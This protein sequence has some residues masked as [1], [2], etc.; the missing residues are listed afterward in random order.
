MTI[1]VRFSEH[2]RYDIMKDAE[3]KMFMATTTK[4]SYFAEFVTNGPQSIRD[5]KKR[6]KE[7]TIEAIQRGEAPREI[8]LGTD[9]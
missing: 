9:G 5:M 8:E 6:F 3:V 7:R 4:G 1:T 2:D